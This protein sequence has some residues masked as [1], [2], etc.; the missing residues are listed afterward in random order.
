MGTFV[1][2]EIQGRLAEDIVVLPRSV[3]RPDS[4]VLIAT[5]ERLLDVRQVSVARAEPREVFI[6]SGIEAGELVVT[7]SMDA[8]IPGT[9][10]AISGEDSSPAEMAGDGSESAV[11]VAGA[12][13]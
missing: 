9:R 3:L 1:R 11:A 4:T 8:P 6:S 12:E 7:T 5:D 2:A 13:Q 10:L